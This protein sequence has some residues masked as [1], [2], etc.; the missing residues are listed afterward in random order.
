MA[1]QV[2]CKA[3]NHKKKQNDQVKKDSARLAWI[4]GAM[5]HE[6]GSNARRFAAARTNDCAAGASAILRTA[7]ATHTGTAHSILPERPRCVSLVSLP[8]GRYRRKCSA[9]YL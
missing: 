6:L 7:R 8:V 1:H 5:L 3:K 4:R 2:Q 9:L